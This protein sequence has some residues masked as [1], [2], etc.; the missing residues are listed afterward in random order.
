MKF[1]SQLLLTLALYIGAIATPA[2]AGDKDPLFIGLS[3]DSS[4]RVGHVLHFSGFQMSR[5]HPLT[6][7]L[8]ESGIFLASKKYSEKH[9]VHQKAL[10]ELMSKG[11]TVLV[12]QYCMKQLEVNES[13]LLPGF[14]PGNPDL[15]G[16][17][18]FKD[19]TRTL[20]W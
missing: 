14:T 13:D 18:I 5:G 2:L 12:C 17:A 1:I 19:N 8:N 7:W 9:A 4:P 20:T 10:A 11:A 15:V 16:G 6:I 3:S